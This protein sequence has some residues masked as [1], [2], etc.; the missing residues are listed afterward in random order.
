MTTKIPTDITVP[1]VPTGTAA[2]GERSSSVT[3]LKAIDLNDLWRVYN[4]GTRAEV[5]ALRGVNLRVEAG[6]FVA[7]KGR[8]GSG[9]TTLLNCVGGLDRP[10]RGTIH[11]FGYEPYALNEKELTRF[12]REQVGFIF[13]SFGLSF[14]YSA[15]ENIELMLRIKGVP[16]RQRRERVLYCLNLVGLEKWKNHRPD[17]LSGG[18]QQRVAIARAL[19][20]QPR[21]IL[22][23][24]PTGDLDSGTAKEILAIFRRIVAEE[25][26]TL[27][28]SSHD[29]VVEEFVDRTLNLKDG[30]VVSDNHPVNS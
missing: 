4:P 28:I 11:V 20:N 5:Q 3:P 26:V 7:L 17:E 22:A 19:V 13:Q 16:V 25:K 8:S 2:A 1:P 15:Y 21:L 12:R 6:S 24:E 30:Q 18:Q 14:N 29:P 9:K 27:F 23:D 10:T